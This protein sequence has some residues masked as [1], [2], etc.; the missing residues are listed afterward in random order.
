MRLSP[1]LCAAA[2]SVAATGVASANVI[3][4]GDF[5]M[6]SPTTT[7]PTEFG[8]AA[9][10]GFTSQQFITDWTGNAGYE[11][12]YPN[13]TAATTVEAYSVWGQGGA[14]TGE[15]KLYGPISA[16]PG[17]TAFVGLDGDQQL[18]GSGRQVQ[19]SISQTVNGLVA[20]DTYAVTFDWAGAQ[21]QSRTGATTES[22]AVSLGGQTLDTTTLDNA[23]E[24]FTGW[25]TATLDFTATSSSEVLSFLSV[26]TPSSLPP[27]A[28]LTNVSMNTVPEPASLALFGGGLLA[29][30]ALV[31]T[32]RR[33]ALRDLT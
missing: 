32:R 14:N 1:L 12:W 4:N 5:S 20:G 9:F 7:A 28:L 26:G 21:M 16:P 8:T 23:S 3:E 22:L 18:D 15:E 30:G 27:M 24:G 29:L 2:L 10:N 33:R 19:S 31:V 13:A 17:A 11:I 25:N 6:T